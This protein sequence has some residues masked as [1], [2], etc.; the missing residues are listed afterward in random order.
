MS[1]TSSICEHRDLSLKHLLGTNCTIRGWD[2]V[3]YSEVVRLPHLSVVV[4]AQW[5]DDDAGVLALCMD[6]ALVC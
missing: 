1:T 6:G 2:N 3:T 4:S 5:M